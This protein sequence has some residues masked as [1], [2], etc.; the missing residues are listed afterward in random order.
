MNWQGKATY[1]AGLVFVFCKAVRA[2]KESPVTMCSR[3][4]CKTA[5]GVRTPLLWNVSRSLTRVAPRRAIP[6]P[7]ARSRWFDSRLRVVLRAPWAAL[8]GDTRTGWFSCV[9]A[10]AC[11]GRLTPH[12]T[13]LPPSSPAP[14]GHFHLAP[15]PL[16]R[17]A[18]PSGSHTPS[19]RIVPPRRTFR[20]DHLP[21][22]ISRPLGPLTYITPRVSRKQL[23]ETGPT[24]LPSHS[25]QTPE[26]VVL[27]RC[28]TDI[29]LPSLP[30]PDC[31][32]LTFRFSAPARLSQQ[33]AV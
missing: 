32:S 27:P 15:S 25:G 8:M 2:A 14:S 20:E 6:F 26:M 1:P 9:R 12:L 21:T 11:L 18:T 4:V 13:L 24:S 30:L 10:S 5:A 16:L 33:W 31:L 3:L 7:T 29:R 22:T 17:A 19:R 28:H 23:A